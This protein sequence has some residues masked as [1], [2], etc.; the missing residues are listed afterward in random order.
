MRR[1]LF[2]IAAAALLAPTAALPARQFNV[3]NPGDY[4]SFA[5]NWTPDTAPLCA[6][7]GSADQWDHVLHP[8]ATM[9][10]HKPFAPPADF[11]N[12][13][14]VLLLARI[15]DAGDLSKVFQVDDVL[16]RKDTIDVTLRFK[17][18]PPAS[19]RMKAYIAVAVDKPIPARVR[20]IQDGSIVCVLDTAAGTWIASPPQP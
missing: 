11:W 7:M 12:R 18:T 16:R 9:G 14:V 1:I 4:Q 15:V 6:A 19:S 20:F 17:P 13:H 5:G 3:L 2:L 10:S 8:A